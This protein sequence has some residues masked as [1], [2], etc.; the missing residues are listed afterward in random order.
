MSLDAFNPV[1]IFS[2]GRR[3]GIM[4]FFTGGGFLGNIIRGLGQKFGL[5]K[6]FDE[7]TY[8]MRRF[9][10]VRSNFSKRIQVTE[11]ALA[12]R[13]IKSEYLWLLMMT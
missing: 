8:D 11:F 12:N 5:G 6:R 4:D 7:P 2:A 9:S 10:A 1:C 13:A 3:G